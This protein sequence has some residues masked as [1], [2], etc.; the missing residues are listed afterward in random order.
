MHGLINIKFKMNLSIN[1]KFFQMYMR[2]IFT[3]HILSTFFVTSL[4]V[5]CSEQSVYLDF[6]SLISVGEESKL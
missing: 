2:I 6:K 1:T 3:T 5:C 4:R